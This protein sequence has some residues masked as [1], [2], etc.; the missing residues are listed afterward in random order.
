MAL[1]MLSTFVLIEL[2]VV[3]HSVFAFQVIFELQVAM[4]GDLVS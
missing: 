3:L 4:L 1:P 2:F